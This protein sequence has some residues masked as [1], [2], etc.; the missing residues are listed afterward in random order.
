M[1]EALDIR[2]MAASSP[3]LKRRRERLARIFDRPTPPD[4]VEVARA[5]ADIARREADL[6]RRE[7]EAHGVFVA[8]H[9]K[10]RAA[11]MAREREARVRLDA[12]LRA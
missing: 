11:V 2:G 6:T 3:S 12:E 5:E 7:Q 4:A 1:T 10:R 8:E 9:E